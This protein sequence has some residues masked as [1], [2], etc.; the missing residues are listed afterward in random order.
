MFLSHGLGLV[1]RICTKP[2]IAGEFLFFVT[3]TPKALGTSTAGI[4]PFGFC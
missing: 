3:E 1:I 4:F 2:G